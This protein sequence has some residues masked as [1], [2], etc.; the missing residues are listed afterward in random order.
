[1]TYYRDLLQP[2]QSDPSCPLEPRMS[3][4]SRGRPG[5]YVLVLLLRRDLFGH[6]GRSG[7]AF[8]AKFDGGFLQQ[9][10]PAWFHPHCC[11]WYIYI[12][13]PLVNIQI[14]IENGNLWWIYPLKMGGSFHSYVSLP[15]GIY[16]YSVHRI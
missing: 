7:A 13:Y 4:Q 1:M 9:G 10:F 6:T 3:G 15:E 5:S 14:A 11:Q 2:F 8:H 16:I 12:I